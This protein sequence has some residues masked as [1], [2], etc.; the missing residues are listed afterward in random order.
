M[1]IQVRIFSGKQNNPSITCEWPGRDTVWS[2]PL[3]E[4]SS[5]FRKSFLKSFARRYLL[6]CSRCL[7]RTGTACHKCYIFRFFK[8]TSYVCTPCQPH[9]QLSRSSLDTITSSSGLLMLIQGKALAKALAFPCLPGMTV[10]PFPKAHAVRAGAGTALGYSLN[11]SCT[12]VGKA[13][14][15]GGIQ[16][17]FHA[18][19]TTQPNL[20]G[21]RKEGKPVLLTQQRRGRG[22]A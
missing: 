10:P 13:P 1:L 4:A 19:E 17:G 6:Q 18:I 9:A 14:T 3:W 7:C 8:K 5:N 21:K 12:C 2:D 11:Q 20:G 16:W 15:G 22:L